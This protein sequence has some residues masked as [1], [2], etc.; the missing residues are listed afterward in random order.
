MWY[1]PY[2][3]KYYIRGMGRSARQDLADTRN[4]QLESQGFTGWS[5]PAYGPER[6]VPVTDAIMSA[7]PKDQVE[8]PATAPITAGSI[9]GYQ[10][11]FQHLLRRPGFAHGGWVPKEG[12]GSQDVSVAFPTTREGTR[13]ALQMA[14]YGNQEALGQLSPRFIG[15]SN[16]IDDL[17]IPTHLLRGAYGSG[18]PHAFPEEM[19]VSEFTRDDGKSVTRIIPSRSEMVDVEAKSMWNKAQK[20]R[21]RHIKAAD[22]WE[23][24]QAK[25]ASPAPEAP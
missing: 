3:A 17:T 7:L 19:Q 5:M 1:L 21:R 25:K 2:M 6:G 14:T 10:R 20:R 11:R 15:D 4:A 23:K 22:E 16:Y 12:T 9:G 18:D 24:E 8:R 13:S